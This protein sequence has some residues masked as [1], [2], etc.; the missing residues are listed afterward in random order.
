LVTRKKVKNKTKR[1]VMEIWATSKGMAA[2]E[3]QR[4]EEKPINAGV[5]RPSGCAP[6]ERQR[7][8]AVLIA[9]LK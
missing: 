7:G 1:K 4:T 6:R 5:V 3:I 2:S 8:I 9:V